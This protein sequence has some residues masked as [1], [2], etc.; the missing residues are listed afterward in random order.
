[1][2]MWG[3]RD[4]PVIE[5]GYTVLHSRDHFVEEISTKDGAKCAVLNEKKVSYN[6]RWT[7]PLEAS[8]PLTCRYK[9][10]HFHFDA[11]Y[12]AYCSNDFPAPGMP[13]IPDLEYKPEE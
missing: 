9:L 4:T 2:R 1:M 5:H 13:C 10:L 6:H 11:A 3:V 7:V 8:V 12:R